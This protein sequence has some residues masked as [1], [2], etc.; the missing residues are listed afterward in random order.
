LSP[1]GRFLAFTNTDTKANTKQDIWILPLFG[2]RKA[3]AFLQTPFDEFGAQ[4][5]PDGWRRQNFSYR[6][7]PAWQKIDSISWMPVRLAVKRALFWHC[8]KQSVDDN[9]QTDKQNYEAG[10]LSG[11]VPSFA[12]S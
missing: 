4:F 3:Y 7:D 9:S 8:E 12:P 2:E 11:I 10:G 5:S 6:S 1:D